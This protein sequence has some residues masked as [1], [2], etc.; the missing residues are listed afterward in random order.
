MSIQNQ[1]VFGTSGNLDWATTANNTQ[2]VGATQPTD[3][4]NFAT[5]TFQ[6]FPQNQVPNQQV[7]STQDLKQNTQNPASPNP[8][9]SFSGKDITVQYLNTQ[10]ELAGFIYNEVPFAT[11]A[12]RQTHIE[13]TY[14]DLLKKLKL[15]ENKDLKIDKY[16]VTKKDG[17]E[18]FEKVTTGRTTQVTLAPK[19]EGSAATHSKVVSLIG[20]A[21]V[22]ED[23]SFN[24][25]KALEEYTKYMEGHKDY[26]KVNN[27]LK[28]PAYFVFKPIQE[29][30]EKADT[31]AFSDN[32]YGDKLGSGACDINELPCKIVRPKEFLTKL[33]ENCSGTDI[34]PAIQVKSFVKAGKVNYLKIVP[35]IERKSSGKD[36]ISFLY[37]AIGADSEQLRQ[38]EL[39][40][41]VSKNPYEAAKKLG[42]S[43]NIGFLHDSR[44]KNV[45]IDSKNIVPESVDEHKI[46]C[47]TVNNKSMYVKPNTFNT[48]KEVPARKNAQGEVNEEYKNYIAD[49]KLKYTEN[50]DF[51]T[52]V[53]ISEKT[54]NEVVEKKATAKT[55]KV[56]QLSATTETWKNL[57]ATSLNLK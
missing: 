43:Y 23:G 24:S 49:R 18:V 15:E 13:K 53:G 22:K 48:K 5:S 37:A 56:F 34:L 4:Q 31:T 2:F 50:K 52:E 11:P 46:V 51:C 14:N 41:D 47:K 26:F 29:G 6:N 36:R 19:T 17:K 45:V 9:T 3:P 10:I 8:A 57:N 38:R 54:F 30:K 12:K 28:N 39:F 42:I 44:D 27:P 25:T 21:N 40:N 33:I 16:T 7:P 32:F 1:N 55:N 35:N 20:M